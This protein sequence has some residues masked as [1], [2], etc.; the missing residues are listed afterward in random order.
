VTEQHADAKAD[1]RVEM[2]ADGRVM[3]IWINRPEARNALSDDFRTGCLAALEAAGRDDRV[4]AVVIR[5]AGG[6]FSAGGDVKRMG[7]RSPAQ[8]TTRLMR[9]R[10]LIENIQSLDKPVIA[11]VE[12]YAVGAGWGLALACD[13]VVASESAR[14][15]MAFV[16]RGLAPDSAVSF[17][18]TRQ[19]G[20]YRT[21]D[22]LMSGRMIDAQ[23]ALGM[24]LVSRVWAP[25]EFDAE[26]DKLV[27][28]LA[29]G[30]TVAQALAKRV[31]WR[32]THLDFAT[33]WDFESLASAVSSTTKDHAEARNAWLNKQEPV[34]EGE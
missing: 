10:T 11:A 17:F 4:R 21:K 29:A 20:L 26:L 13:L 24:G 33:V 23:E 12:G 6:H 5:G 3:T 25:Q 14:F 28:D 1:A 15:Q 27:G 32:A 7:T 31:T 18:L 30:P 16:R 9:A 22:L 2:T 34:F 8:G 19:V